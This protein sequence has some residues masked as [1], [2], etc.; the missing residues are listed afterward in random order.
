MVGLAE[1]AQLCYAKL[2][3]AVNHVHSQNTKGRAVQLCKLVYT[4]HLFLPK[5]TKHLSALAFSL[6]Y[7]CIELSSL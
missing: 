5:V 4:V 3:S 7:L 1:S 6:S 2:I